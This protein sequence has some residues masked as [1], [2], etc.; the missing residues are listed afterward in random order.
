MLRHV[1][2]Q[3]T[4]SKLDISVIMC[5]TCKSTDQVFMSWLFQSKLHIHASDSV[6]IF[7]SYLY[8]IITYFMISTLNL[9]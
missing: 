2:N 5:K 7:W 3:A 9:L 1:S 4:V 8:Y 6:L